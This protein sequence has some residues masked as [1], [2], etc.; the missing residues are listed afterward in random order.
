MIVARVGPTNWVVC[1]YARV[2]T[3]KRWIV[4]AVL[5]VLAAPAWLFMGS[6]LVLAVRENA[7]PGLDNLSLPAGT[8]IIAT[9]RGCG[10]G[11]C[12]NEVELRPADGTTNAQLLDELGVTGGRE[13][14]KNEGPPMF[15]TTCLYRDTSVRHQDRAVIAFYYKRVQ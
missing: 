10:S 1:V 8:T 4:T 12:W 3:V 15:W 14:C 11:G 9:Q 5:A 13:A 7:V 6:P 2:V